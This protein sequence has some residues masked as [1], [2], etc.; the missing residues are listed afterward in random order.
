MN[1]RAAVLV[2]FPLDC[3]GDSVLFPPEV[4]TESCDFGFTC[5][6]SPS[7]LRIARFASSDVSFCQC[8]QASEYRTLFKVPPVG[9]VIVLPPSKVTVTCRSLVSNML[10]FEFGRR[11]SLCP[12]SS[13]HI[14]LPPHIPSHALPFQVSEESPDLSATR[15]RQ[16]LI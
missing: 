7:P 12:S 2:L 5:P 3:L 11:Y 6:L 8:I 1:I 13:R 15:P 9:K 14:C 10:C 4:L 16:V